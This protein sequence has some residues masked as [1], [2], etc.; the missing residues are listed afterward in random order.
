MLL[1]DADD[2]RVGTEQVDAVYLGSTLVWQSLDP[3]AAAFLTAAAI[4]DPTITSAIGDLVAALK[5]ASVWSKVDAIY[6]FVGGTE[7]TH[8]LNLKDP[9]NLDAAFRLAFG[10]GWVHSANGIQPNGASTYADTFWSPTVHA[11]VS[12]IS[13]GLYS[14]TE[15]GSGQ[16]Q[17]YDMGCDGGSDTSATLCIARYASNRSYYGVGTQT[18]GCSIA[19][20]DGRGFYC[21][22]RRDGTT[23][24][25]YRNGAPHISYAE[26]AAPANVSVY[27]GCIHK[28]GGPTYYSGKQQ[29]FAFLGNAL[30]DAD[31][32]NLYTAVQAFQTTLGRQV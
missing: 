10:P 1:A 12:D 4:T 3:D 6:P 21:T 17:P 31:V 20:T 28:P 25:G 9:R 5:A 30:S 24:R 32:A 14:R 22:V 27:L 18:Y 26:A 23:T 15:D 16:G 2:I 29:A 11:S 7:A 19:N 13:L 8:Q